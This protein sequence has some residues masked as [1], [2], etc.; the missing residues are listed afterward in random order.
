MFLYESNLKDCSFFFKRISIY[1][2][3][4]DI[5]FLKILCG[6]GSKMREKQQQMKVDDDDDDD[7]IT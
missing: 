6:I 7:E 5:Y 2:T 4:I 1:Y 3:Y